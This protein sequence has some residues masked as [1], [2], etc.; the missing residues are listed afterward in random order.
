MMQQSR[1]LDPRS[2]G[3][4]SPLHCTHLTSGKGWL[5]S[6]KSGTLASEIWTPGNPCPWSIKNA[7][8]SLARVMT[9]ALL[10]K[11]HSHQ[12]LSS[13]QTAP[14]PQEAARSLPVFTLPFLFCTQV[15]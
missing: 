15:L 7:A 8:C 10:V 4:H 5:T 11:A 14:R 13:S 12:V 1:R 3:Q 2:S 9:P 6:E